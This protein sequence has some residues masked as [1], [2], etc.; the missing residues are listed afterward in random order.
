MA[1]PLE[2]RSAP[3]ERQLVDPSLQPKGPRAVMP[4]DLA[5][6]DVIAARSKDSAAINAIEYQLNREG[7]QFFRTHDGP[8]VDQWIQI[9]VR[10]EDRE[11][12]SL[13]ATATLQRRQKM[14]ALKRK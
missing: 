4:M 11:R 3:V 13:I 2:Y 14:L 12:A 8:A 5:G 10:A 6:F 1:Q 9:L 7:V